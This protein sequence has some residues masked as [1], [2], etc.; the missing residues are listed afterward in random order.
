MIDKL[1][2]FVWINPLKNK[3]AQTKRN[4]F[5]QVIKTSK[6]KT[7]LLE[8]DNGAKYVSKI[9]KFFLKQNKIKRHSR[10]TSRG[11]VFSIEAYTVH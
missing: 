1:Y 3:N 6:P 4:A 8:T 10:C 2:K 11:A 9:F 7:N 5:S